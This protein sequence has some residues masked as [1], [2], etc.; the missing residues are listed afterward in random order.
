MEQPMNSQPT[1]QPAADEDAVRAINQRMIDAWN[2]G[3]AAA[4]AAP[5]TDEANFVAFEGTH[6]K[7][8]REIASFHQQIFDTVVKGTRLQGEVKFVRFLSAALAVMHSVVRVTLQGQTE[9]SPSRDSM[10]LTVVAKRDGEWRGEGLMNARRLTVE[11]QFFLDDM[12][13][14]PAEAQRQVTDLMVSLKKHHLL[15]TY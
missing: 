3:D 14:L 15:K 8:R 7:G 9:A 12:D 6:L 10:Q 11:R 4:F 2:T 1:T 5:F 13:S